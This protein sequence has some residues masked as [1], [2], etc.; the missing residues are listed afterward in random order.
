MDKLNTLIENLRHLKWY[1]VIALFGGIV[2][3]GFHNEIT[4]VIDLRLSATDIVVRS[5]END[6]LIDKALTDLLEATESD[7]A[8]IFR[9]H[10]GDTYYN[11]THK[12]KMSN[13]Y[14]V[15][16]LGVVPQ[17]S[18][19]QNI[20]TSLYLSWIKETIDGRMF[21]YDINNITD[22]RVRYSLKEQGIK[23]IA[24]A[25]YYRD[26]KLFA[27]IGIDYIREVSLEDILRFKANKQEA[28]DSFFSKANEIGNLLI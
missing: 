5:I 14:E 21:Y 4:R 18:K 13:D 2:L 8:Y 22:L 11:G 27:I 20:P 7:R 12:S 17:A 26:G 10:N 6:L 1:T 16:K 19:L 15:V 24:C 23:A 9:F 28:K 3:Y 25:P